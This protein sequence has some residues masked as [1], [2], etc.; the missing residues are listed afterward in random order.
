MD[1]LSAHQDAEASG[2]FDWLLDDA[3]PTLLAFLDLLDND[4]DLAIEAVALPVH[5]PVEIK[6]EAKRKSSTWR[7]RQRLKVLRLRD[8]VKELDEELK[9]MKLSTG[10]RSTL[11]LIEGV[12]SI[13]NQLKRPAARKL[14]GE[15]WQDAASRESHARHLSSVENERLHRVLHMQAKHA[16]KLHRMMQQQ[17][18]NT[19]V[20]QAL[21]YRPA[22]TDDECRPPTDNSIVFQKLLADLDGHHGNVRSIFVVNQTD[23]EHEGYVSINPA[24]GLQVRIA[25]S[26]AFPFSVKATEQAIWNILTERNGIDQKSRVVYNERFEVDNNTSL[27]SV[28]TF[29]VSG[30]YELC[31]LVR[32]GCRRYVKDDLTHF[33]VHETSIVSSSFGAGVSYDEVVLRTVSKGKERPGGP[34]AIAETHVL[35]TFPSYETLSCLPPD[36]LKGFHDACMRFNHKVEDVLVSH[37]T[38]K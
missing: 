23:G 10:V 35:A 19:I 27:Q 24:R 6:P 20:S 13:A 38:L 16:R 3:A 30:P 28:R 36:G 37:S 17:M 29:I 15:A 8:E 34:T 33:V 2:T 26:Y 14:M 1:D 21:G 12:S 4:A 11:P 18:S 9:K 5:R 25:K 31:F 22:L 7:Q 32:K